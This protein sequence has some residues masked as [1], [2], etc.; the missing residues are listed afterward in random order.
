[1]FSYAEVLLYRGS[2]YA[3][4]LLYRGSSIQRFFYNTGFNLQRE[5]VR[6]INMV[7]GRLNDC[8]FLVVMI[9]VYIHL[10]LLYKY[11]V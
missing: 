9:L 11:Q 8:L 1:M 4:V 7:I 10:S 3:E 5:S 6:L 2:S